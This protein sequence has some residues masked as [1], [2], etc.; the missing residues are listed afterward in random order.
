MKKIASLAT[1]TIEIKDSKFIAYGSECKTE[2]QARD[3]IV[4]IK[5]KH[6]KA[7]HH[8]YAYITNQ[9]AITRSFD[10]KE[11]SS[12]AGVVILKVL[13]GF[14][15]NDVCVVVVRYFGGTL[16]GRGG[17][18]KAYSQVSSQL[19]HSAGIIT[20]KQIYHYT[21]KFPYEYIADVESYLKNK[22]HYIHRTYDND[23]VI[24]F[25]IDD[26]DNMFQDIQDITKGNGLL[27]LVN[28][29]WV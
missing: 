2:K 22:A 25:S 19:I 27:D 20:M 1:E 18:I 7:N 17:L 23:I 11:P 3:F 10:D 16:L 24:S 14:Q 6:P 28:T 15:L 29:E 13:Q 21:L 12:T 5:N 8:C 9:S 4:N 26:P